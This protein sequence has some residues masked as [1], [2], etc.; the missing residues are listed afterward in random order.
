MVGTSGRSFERSRDPIAKARSLPSLICGA[1][2]SV[3]AKYMSTRPPSASCMA[4][5]A[6]L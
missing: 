5:G 6:A 3:D 1:V 4:C 2:V